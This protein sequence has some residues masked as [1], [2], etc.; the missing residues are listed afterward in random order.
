MY[1]G[2]PWLIEINASPAIG[3]TTSVTTRMVPPLLKDL[4]AVT[5][6]GG[7]GDQAGT[8]HN[9][10]VPPVGAVVGQLECVYSGGGE[11]GGGGG[12]GGRR[13]SKDEDKKLVSQTYSRLDL[14]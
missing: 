5:T 2:S 3:A 9:P 6:S 13:G 7:H 14:S 10:W 11:H 4:L 8:A 1:Y 12:A